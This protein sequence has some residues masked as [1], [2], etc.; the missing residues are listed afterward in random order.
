MKKCCVRIKTIEEQC[1]CRWLQ[2]IYR[3]PLSLSDG[4]LS[5]KV[6]RRLAEVGANSHSSGELGE[7][8]Q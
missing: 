4:W 1:M 7:L 5:P 3:T 6:S 2:P 8:S